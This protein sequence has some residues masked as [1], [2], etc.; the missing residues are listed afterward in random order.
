MNQPRLGL[1]VLGLISGTALAGPADSPTSN[2]F[3]Q[4]IRTEFTRADR[5]PSV[6]VQRVAVDTKGR[7]WAATAGGTT[8]FDG[9]SW[10]SPLGSARAIVSEAAVDASGFLWAVPVPPE[11]GVALMLRGTV[12]KQSELSSVSI[13]FTGSGLL[14]D[15]A[16]GG[17]RV[18][19]AGERGLWHTNP[20]AEALSP[21]REAFQGDQLLG[22]VHCTRVA[23]SDSGYVAVVVDDHDVSL[24]EARGEWQQLGHVAVKIRQLEFDTDD[25]LNA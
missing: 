20:H 25:N 3:S 17:T 11:R 8:R 22:A 13:G 9:R 15:V 16:F 2:S 23:A 12:I 4:E 7:V 14:R 21:V 24:R 5:L 19:V 1:A 18:Y 6:D 10:S